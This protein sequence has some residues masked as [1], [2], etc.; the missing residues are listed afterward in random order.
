MGHVNVKSRKKEERYEAKT[1]PCPKDMARPT[2]Y[3]PEMRALQIVE[4][5]K[6]YRRKKLSKASKQTMSN[7][8]IG[9]M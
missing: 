6:T 9:G 3:V 1:P 7:R 4:S 2:V 5:I 8:C